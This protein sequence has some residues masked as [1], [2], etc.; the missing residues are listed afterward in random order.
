MLLR[1]FDY[2]DAQPKC[3]LVENFCNETELL[4]EVYTF[5][6]QTKRLQQDVGFFLTV[7]EG[8]TTDS[9]GRDH[10]LTELANKYQ[11][12]MRVTLTCNE[13]EY[14]YYSYGTENYECVLS[15][16]YDEP[17]SPFDVVAYPEKPGHI[18]STNLSMYYRRNTTMWV[19]YD[20]ANK[21]STNTPWHP[22]HCRSDRP[23]VPDWNFF[24]NTCWFTHDGYN[25]PHNWFVTVPNNPQTGT[26][27]VWVKINQAIRTGDIWRTYDSVNKLSWEMKKLDHGL[28]EVY[29]T[30]GVGQIP[31][32]LE[33]AGRPVDWMGYIN[34]TNSWQH[35]CYVWYM[36]GSSGYAEFYINAL[37]ST[38]LNGAE[39][40]TNFAFQHIGT[41]IQLG[42]L[43][44]AWQA[45]RLY[46][47]RLTEDQIFDLYKY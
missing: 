13:A 33:N 32:Y 16:L 1:D 18:P 42:E 37:K 35:L 43:V 11:L 24:E 31:Y 2:L 34:N 27:C 15:S 39:L 7:D 12:G 29:V 4:D 30:V 28:Y 10:N 19:Q 25:Q 6:K 26:W 21:R 17:A 41:R 36:P 22:L 8:I 14:Y 45:P 9:Q 47:Y 5:E 44:T 46:N 38:T 23:M 40:L 20:K 3:E